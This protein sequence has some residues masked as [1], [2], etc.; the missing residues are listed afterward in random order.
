[1]TSHPDTHT[2]FLGARRL[3]AGSLHAVA[4]AVLRA[5]RD[6]PDAMPLVFHDATGRQ[7]DLDLRGNPDEVAAR[8]PQPPTA[9]APPAEPEPKGRG[10]PRLGVVAREVTLL[11]EHWDWLGAQPGGASVA[12]RK[13]VHEARRANADRERARQAQER[14]WHV[15]SALAGNLPG[16]EEAGRALFAGDRE[17]LAQ[18]VA[19]WPAD[20]GAYVLALAEPGAAGAGAPSTKGIDE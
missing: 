4:L 8:Y 18:R 1:M 2:A 17:Q 14:A 19:S 10:R 7:I 11:P 12:L 13:L 5:Q 6:H 9:P 16:L 15:M 3:A 20:V